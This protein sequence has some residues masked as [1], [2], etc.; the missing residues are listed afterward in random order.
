MGIGRALQQAFKAMMRII[1]FKTKNTNNSH[2]YIH[3]L[4]LILR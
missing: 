3:P 4:K 1:G 2:R